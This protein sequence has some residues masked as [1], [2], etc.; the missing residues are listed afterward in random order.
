MFLIIV[1]APYKKYFQVAEVFRILA[2]PNMFPC[3][4]HRDS[5][6]CVS[7]IYPIV[8]ATPNALLSYNLNILS[9]IK[10]VVT[11]EADLMIT[12]GGK[13]VWTILNF[14]NKRVNDFQKTRWIKEKKRKFPI[15]NLKRLTERQFIFA[16][17]T[18]PSRGRKAA[19]NVLQDWLPDSEL[20]V[21]EAVHNTVP[22]AKM[23]YVKVEQHTKLPQL[24]KTLNIIAG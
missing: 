16:A 6:L 15:N 19:S 20:I 14:F 22:T 10:T 11:D 17:A 3:I 9:S 23:H 7:K 2:E 18:L 5:R 12:S 4:V 21:T 1:V 8:M 24:S 13:D